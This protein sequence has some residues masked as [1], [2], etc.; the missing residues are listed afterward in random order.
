[1]QDVL[2]ELNNKNS[3]DLDSTY[4]AKIQVENKKSSGLYITDREGPNCGI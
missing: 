1:M 3:S 4:P 2:N